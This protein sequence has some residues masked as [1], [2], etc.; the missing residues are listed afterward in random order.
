MENEL[1]NNFHSVEASDLVNEEIDEDS[2]FK[3]VSLDETESEHIAAEPYSYW[4]AVFR[5]F[6][7]KP[8]AIISL[9]SLAILLLGMIIIPLFA[10][11]GSMEVTAQSS[12]LANLAPSL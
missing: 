1:K 8:A 9:T 11:E 6:I 10:P 3:R 4:K 2:L 7:K 12:K 5:V